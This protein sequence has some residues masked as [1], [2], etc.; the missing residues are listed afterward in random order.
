MSSKVYELALLFTGHMVDLPG[1][2]EPRFPAKAERAVGK[3]VST[4]VRA[5]KSAIKGRTIGVASA[6]RGGDILFLEA[7]GLFGIETRIV[8]PFPPQEF[9]VTS[10]AGVPSGR[11]ERRFWACWD[12]HQTGQ[13]EV[14]LDRAESSGYALAN[15]RMLAMA[16]ALADTLELIALWDGQDGDGAGGTGAFVALVQAAGG[17]VRVINPLTPAT[18]A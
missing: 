7:C 4:A 15:D 17:R 18:S 3:A 13:R 9:V 8:L 14:V 10:V 5:A 6:A 2:P 12:A 16:K 1:R 11:W